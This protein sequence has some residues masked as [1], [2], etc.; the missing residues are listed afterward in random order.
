METSCGQIHHHRRYVH[1]LMPCHALYEWILCTLVIGCVGYMHYY[2]FCSVLPVILYIL[3]GEYCE[4]IAE[5]LNFIRI[6]AAV[7]DMVNAL[8]LANSLLF[9]YMHV[10]YECVNVIWW[11][12]VYAVGLNVA[13]TETYSI[14]W[15]GSC[16]FNFVRFCVIEYWLN[17]Y[18]LS[19][20]SVNMC[21]LMVL[22]VFA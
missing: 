10:L 8:D 14:D 13:A 21:N 1:Q 16:L 5:T 19:T 11:S 9:D 22:D 20:K 12:A 15:I 17:I 3:I 7:D 6:F 18:C 2:Y 4:W